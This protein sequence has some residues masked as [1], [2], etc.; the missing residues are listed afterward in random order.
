[1]WG[2][3]ADTGA[4]ACVKAL[5]SPRTKARGS[6]ARSLLTVR[7][8]ALGYAAYVIVLGALAAYRWH[9]WT[10][11]TDTGTFAQVVASTFGG[12]RDGPE[13]GTHFRF[14]WAPL[15]SALWPLV[16]ATRSPLALQLA[17]I[18]LVGAAAFPL[19]ALARGYLAERTAEYAGALALI[20]PPLAAVAFDEFHEIAFY[21]AIALGL[22]WAADRARWRWFAIFA[23]LSALIRED[24]C[25]VLVVAGVA[26]GTV[27][28]LRRRS[29]GAGLLL[30]APREPERLAVAGFGLAALNAAA[31]GIY[32][33]IVIPHVG[34]WQPSRFYD[35]P[36]AQGPLALV[37]A[38]IT[39]PAYLG[40]LAQLGR[41][42]YLLEAF[43]PLALLPLL[44]RW[45][46]LALPGFAIVLLAS[47]QIAWR[48][49][50]HYA[51]LWIP[52]VLLGA[53]AA[54]AAMRKRAGGPTTARWSGAALVL[55]AI[56]LI[57]FNPMHAGHYLRPVY[58][59]DGARRALAT[60]PSGAFLVTHDEWFAR[61]A[62]A[63]PNASV[64]F[65][66]YATY[67]VY[68]DDFPNGYFKDQILPELGREVASGQ[69]RVVASFGAVRVY[70]RTPN[71]GARVGDCVTPGNVRY[72]SLRDTLGSR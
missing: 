45:T 54:L 25:V 62:L 5:L 26:L 49:G 4:G 50:S 29:D 21:P 24:A 10:Y 17:Q 28:L 44:S 19:Y 31:L 27:G 36:F 2:P 55:C 56:F 34:A 51:A 64:F 53:L 70:A 61:V 35:Y 58:P 33:G 46:L 18:V 3:S 8:I 14:H 7:R 67:A 9:I 40:S 63:Q 52:W 47:D 69:A 48:M 43:V 72:R 23:L 15:L 59:T 1:M 22:V 6:R 20:Y 11:G 39:H 60:V 16:A 68:A 38:L 13:Q 71:P 32:Y 41:F 57:A 42:T 12:F 30:G 37:A 65:C 66:P